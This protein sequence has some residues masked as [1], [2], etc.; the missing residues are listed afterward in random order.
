[1]P[2]AFSAKALITLPKQV[3][4]LLIAQPSW[5]LIPVVPVL[6]DFSEPARSTRLITDDFSD[7]LPLKLIICLNFIVMTV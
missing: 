6:L 1:M 4:L 5:K 2:E 7:F 3:R